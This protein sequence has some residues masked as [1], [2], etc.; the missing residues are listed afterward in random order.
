MSN[1]LK[2]HIPTQVHRRFTFFS[3]R[4]SLLLVSF[5]GAN[6]FRIMRVTYGKPCRNSSSRYFREFGNIAD[7]N[8]CEI[9]FFR[10]LVCCLTRQRAVANHL[11]NNNNVDLNNRASTF[12]S[13]SHNNLIQQ[14]K[15]RVT[16]M[17]CSKMRV[18][19]QKNCRGTN[20]NRIGPMIFDVYGF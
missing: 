4:V 7:I 17:I 18:T 2:T 5:H 19:R 15:M 20:T 16:L 6:V 14:Q 13:N 11:E 1:V 8:E 3:F 12:N 10:L 9:F